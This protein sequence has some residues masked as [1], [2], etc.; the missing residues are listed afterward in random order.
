MKTVTMTT[1]RTYPLNP[2]KNRLLWLLLLGIGVFNVADYFLTLYAL[3]MGCREANP[4]I[5]LVVDSIFFAKIKLLIVPL[6]LLFL[7]VRRKKVRQRLYFYVWLLFVAYMFLML[8]YAWL[9][10]SGS[11]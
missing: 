10:W 4:V 11:L 5:D 3:E 9:F 6:L 1:N 7:W 2:A 8:Y